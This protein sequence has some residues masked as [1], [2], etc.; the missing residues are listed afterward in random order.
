MGAGFLI[1]AALLTQGS[2]T[3]TF[4]N[5]ATRELVLRATTRHYAQDSSVKDYR[6]RIKY[7]LTFSLGRR[8]WANPPPWG[9]EEQEGRVAWQLPN[10]IQVDILGQRSRSRDARGTVYSAFDEPW[11]V[12][13]RLSDSVRVFGNDFPQ[14]A[15]LHPLATDGPS[16]YRYTMGEVLT[17]TT[18]AGREIR[19]VPVTVA[20]KRPGPALLAGQLWLDLETAEVVRFV[21]RYI[22]TDL[23]VSPESEAPKDS[24][25]ARKANQLANRILTL[26][27]DLEYALQDGRYWMP[28]RQVLMGRV[29]LPMVGD[30]FVPFEAIT[31]FDDY[32]IN[33]G[34]KIVFRLPMPD[35]ARTG[36]IEEDREAH[37]DSLIAE[38]RQR[39]SA[40]TVEARNRTGVVDGGRYEIH[41]APRDSLRQY[42][43]DEEI[44]FRTTESEAKRTEQLRREISDL[45]ESLPADLSGR[46][47]TG[48]TYERVVDIF[49]FNRVQGASVGLGY[50]FEL[51]WSDYSSLFVTGRYGF[52]D[53]RPAGRLSFVRDAPVGKLAISAFRDIAEADPFSRG[54]SMGNSMRALVSARDEADYFLATGGLATFETSVSKSAD[55][56]LSGRLEDHRSIE[57][58][59]SAWVHEIYDSG[60]FP[61]NPPVS[62]GWHAGVGGRLDGV[63]GRSRWGLALEG[64]SSVE[65]GDKTARIYGEWRQPIGYRHGG[66]VRLKAGLATRPTLPQMAFRAG[67][68][69]SVRGH[70]YGFQRGDAMWSIQ[71][72]VSTSPR[73]IRGVLFLDAGQAGHLGD[74][75]NARILTGGG[76]GIS[77]FGGLI[78]FELSHP[79]SPRPEGSGLRLDLVLGAPR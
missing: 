35:T 15:S 58:K 27:V 32:E 50:Q 29:Q 75:K 55:L 53:Q 24:A 19:I 64:L 74:L 59:S 3:A 56:T 54:L 47:L 30:V 20:P 4:A 26:D 67:G 41:R 73:T 5:A 69:G 52:S 40:D 39:G 78:R 68:Q 37:R 44:E 79:I 42:Q 23:W 45:V 18:A 65:G 33:T 72:D 51:R 9:A 16:W 46:Y 21:F 25:N 2:D 60:E 34:R 66:T 49:R 28:Y 10:D 38:R 8:R 12:P 61:E 11:F 17:V 14:R 63:A 7:R 43:W 77:M 1:F 6:A 36:R 48:F 76:A 22:G 70:D 62:E 13:R 31:T 71:T 57:K